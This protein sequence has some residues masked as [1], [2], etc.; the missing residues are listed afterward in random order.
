MTPFR[1]LH[2]P[3]EIRNSIYRLLL[4]QPT[5]IGYADRTMNLHPA[6]LRANHQVY[7]EAKHILY[8]ENYFEIGIRHRFDDNLAYFVRCERFAKDVD[9]KLRQFRLIQRYDIYIEVQQEEDILAVKRIVRDVCKVLSEVPR[10]KHLIITLD[11]DSDGDQALLAAFERLESQVEDQNVTPKVSRSSAFLA[12]LNDIIELSSDYSNGILKLSLGNSNGIIELSFEKLSFEKLSFGPWS[13]VKLLP[14]DSNDTIILPGLMIDC[15]KELEELPIKEWLIERIEFLSQRATAL[16]P[17]TYLR[18]VGRVD[19]RGAV[20]PRYKRYLRDVMQGGSPLNHLPKMY[21]ALED[22]A[23]PFYCYED[24]DDAYEAMEDEDVEL[25][26]RVREE[27][28]EKVTARMAIG[29]VTTRMADEEVAARM[30]DAK[31][32]LFDYDAR[33]GA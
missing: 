13:F 32:R 11:Q 30:A 7:D 24:L 15:D 1:F 21:D 12:D 28:I 20:K 27:V 29:N 17:F 18:N 10:I 19:V 14:E 22:Y 3:A 26:K 2:L 6:V 4:C 9:R 25:F 5:T 8:G 31:G 16:Q 23:E 33:T